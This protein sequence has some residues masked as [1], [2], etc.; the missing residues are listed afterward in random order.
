MRQNT[1][2]EVYVISLTGRK[3]VVPYKPDTRV[4][5][6]QDILGYLERNFLSQN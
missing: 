4:R 6:L 3:Y 1:T 2:D 5:D